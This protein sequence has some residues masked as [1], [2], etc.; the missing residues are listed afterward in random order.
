MEAAPQ[1]NY[2]SMMVQVNIPPGILKQFNQ[3]IRDFLWN[4]KKPWINKPVR[5]LHTT[6][7]LGEKWWQTLSNC[8]DL[9]NLGSFMQFGLLS[10]VC[11]EWKCATSFTAYLCYFIYSFCP[12]FSLTFVGILLYVPW[13]VLFFLLGY[14]FFTDLLCYMLSCVAS[15]CLRMQ[16]TSITNTFFSL[17]LF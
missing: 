6:R 15:C 14:L 10:N 3:L 5:K 4:R 11:E 17:F 9:K 1:F 16:K 8:E 13:F 12:L 2:I 7:Y